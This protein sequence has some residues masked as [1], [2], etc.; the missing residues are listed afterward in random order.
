MPATIRALCLAVL[1]A[2]VA[3]CTGG[4]TPAPPAG[5][6]APT[7]SPAQAS[8]S[9][10]EASAAPGGEATVRIANFAFDPPTIEVAA[11]QTI[12]WTN[13]DSAPHT[14]TLDDGSV[15]SGRLD[16]GATFAHAFTTPG[17]FTYHCEIHPSMK[18][19]IEVTG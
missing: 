6:A 1:L 8:P 4:A 5:S 14:V 15:D 9:P 16:Q 12:T 11:G 13:E 17:T 18:G 7:P 10:A 19:T 3:A 2:A